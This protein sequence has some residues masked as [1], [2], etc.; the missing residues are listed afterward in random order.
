MNNEDMNE[1][2]KKAQQMM[3]NNE[4]PDDLKNMISSFQNSTSKS[5]SSFTSQ[6]ENSYSSNNSTTSENINQSNQHRE[7]PDTSTTS[8]S[9]TDF[10]NIDIATLMKMQKVMSRLKNNDV[11]DDNM[12]KLLLSLK[13]YLRDDKKGK[14]DEY[15]QLSKMGKMTQIFEELNKNGFK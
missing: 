15:I 11:T 10:S 6:S 5:G 9:S 13:P 8:K 14:I 12:S 4:I 1:M 7:S 3:Q 2:I